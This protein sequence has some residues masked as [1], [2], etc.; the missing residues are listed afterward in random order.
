MRNIARAAA[1]VLALLPLSVFAQEATLP[2][3][4]NVTVEGV[5]AI[6]V[7]LAEALASYGSARQAL[8]LAWHPTRRQVLIST[9]FGNVPQIHAVSG[10]G[11]DRAQLTFFREGVQRGSTA[12]E[13]I[14]GDYFVFTKDAG[15]GT[16]ALQLFRYDVAT[17]RATMITD[18]KSRYGSPAWSHKASLIAFE[19]SRRNGKD[20]D[21]YVMNPLE[22]A[23]LKMVAQTEGSWSVSAWS[24]DDSELL[25]M[26]AV[27]NEEKHLWRVKVATGEKTLLTEGDKARWDMA[28]YSPDGKSIYGLSNRGGDTLRIWRTDVAGVKWT[29]L[30]KEDEG[31]ESFALSPDG[32]TLAVTFDSTTS[33]RLELIDAATSAV[34]LAPRLPAGQL[35]GAPQW[36]PGGAEVAFSLWSLRTYGDVY[37]VNAKSGGVERWTTSE[38]GPFNPESLPEP[39]IIKWKSFDGVEMSAVLYRPPARFTGPRPVI[40]N[41]HGGPS[42]A[43]ARERPRFQ[44]RSAY[45]LNELGIALLMPN[46]R[47]SFGFGKEFE[48][49]DDGPLRENAVKDIGTLLDWLGK[50]P[51]LDKNRVAVTGASY[52][53]YMTYAVAAMYSDRIRCAMAASGISDFTAYLQTTELQRQSN[54]R[55]EYG[56][57]TDPA[58]AAVLKRISPV[59]NASKIR[60]PLMIVHGIQDT[61]VPIAQGKEMASVVRANGQPVW[62]V[63]FEDEGHFMFRSAANNDFYFYAWMMFVQKFLLTGTAGTGV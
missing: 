56:D 6:P 3:P 8:L 54:R 52:G 24:P 58:M 43:N 32:R 15:G 10:P 61:R 16:E 34:R 48:R 22:P 55:A 17:G 1:V 50:Q 19:C 51:F 29:P 39:E 21:L 23:S 41:I 33:S 26:S 27:T 12:Y 62:T 30:T 36:R 46:V 4:S 7:A 11:M 28:Q 14:H 5:P 47:G 42:G 57:E 45:F 18:G 37:S 44:G 25:A 35:I 60:V 40:I 53:G 63:F 59:T 31:V 49:L 9:R 20:R 2:V 13:P 38:L